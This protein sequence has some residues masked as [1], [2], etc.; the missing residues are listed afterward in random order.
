MN[1]LILE[2]QEEKNKREFLTDLAG[3]YRFPL[4]HTEMT[5]DTEDS[6]ESE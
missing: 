6:Y 2:S 4:T 3:K 5:F 1:I